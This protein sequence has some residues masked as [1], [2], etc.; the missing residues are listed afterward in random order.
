MDELDHKIIALLQMD[1]RASN[2]KIAREV[3][4]SEGT[5]RRRLCRLTK[6]D[7]VHIVAVPNL[8]KLGYATTALVGLQTGPGMSDTVAESLAS[9]P[10]SHYVA[11]TTGSYDVFVWAGLES[12]ESLG[13]FLRTK[14]G[15]IEGVQRTET[16]VN[17]SLKKRTAG[18]V[19]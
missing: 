11:V 15:V 13:N 14:V 4:V 5:V 9:L 19:L 2:A 7:V 16:F 8:E 10:E 3:G 12:A 18:L 6:D 17:L 1:G